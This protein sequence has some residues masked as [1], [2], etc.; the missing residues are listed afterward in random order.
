[1]VW[2][3]IDLKGHLIP[4]SSAMEGMKEGKEEICMLLE[5]AL[6]ILYRLQ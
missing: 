3:G 1:M 4:T 2:T 6:T 5:I